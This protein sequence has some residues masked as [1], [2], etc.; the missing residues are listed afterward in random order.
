MN[1]NN[2][3][4]KKLLMKQNLS[5]S[6]NFNTIQ[7]FTSGIKTRDEKPGNMFLA[8][9]MFAISIPLFLIIVL[10]SVS[11]NSSFLGFMSF[12]IGL[13]VTVFLIRYAI[14]EIYRSFYNHAHV[15]INY[16][17]YFLEDDEKI[18]AVSIGKKTISLGMWL[19][20]VSNLS[21]FAFTSHR[22][23]LITLNKKK[24]ESRTPN[25]YLKNAKLDDIV[26]DILPF[27]LSDNQV[28]K[29][30]GVK[31]KISPPNEE[32]AINWRLMI[33]GC[34]QEL[35]IKEIFEKR[36]GYLNN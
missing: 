10:I 23:L 8:I 6:S 17:K 3:K 31:I 26:I 19:D 20:G 15:L 22:L 11:T 32:K 24:L 1:E 4:K 16:L 12:L 18:L 2:L 7:E 36:D 28:V 33:K 34:Q 25:Y 30:N 21:Y 35:V 27:D 9:I 5:N 14:H 29:L 13:C